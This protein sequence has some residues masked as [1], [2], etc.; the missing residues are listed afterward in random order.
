MVGFVHINKTG[1]TTVK[2]ILRNS[3][4]LRH[5]DLL[6]KRRRAVAEAGDIAFVQKVFFWGINSITGHSLRP[7]V[8]DLP[9]SI[10]YFT[11]LRDPLQ[12]CLSH[13]QHVKR[14]QRRLGRDITFEEFM[15]DQRNTDYQVRHIAGVPD[16]EKAKEILKSRFFFVGLMERFDESMRILQKI[17]PY[18]LTLQY[19]PLHVAKDNKAKQEILNSAADR[20]LL[21]RGNQHDLALYAFVRD[22]LYPV[23]CTQAGLVG[24]E[25]DKPAQQPSA[26]PV[27][28]KLTRFYN[29]GIYRNLNKMRCLILRG[30]T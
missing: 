10:N 13:Y 26:C 20:D 24:H 30:R 16:V 15:H 22:E 12:R 5:C 28:Y 27:R 1:G 9:V 4:W 23:Y 14:A 18:P 7:W 6:P 25:G 8:D 21:S 3:S 29:H 19:R 17:F 11:M 2:F